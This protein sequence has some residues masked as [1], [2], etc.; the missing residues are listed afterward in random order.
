MNTRQ[1]FLSVLASSLIVACGGHTA[2]SPSTQFFTLDDEPS[3]LLSGWNTQ[4]VIGVVDGKNG[5]VPSNNPD[6]G[7]F[8]LLR[9]SNGDATRIPLPKSSSARQVV[10]D[11][12]FD[13]AT[14]SYVFVY[15]N[16]APGTVHTSLAVNWNLAVW[17]PGWTSAKVLDKQEVGLQ[18]WVATTNGIVFYTKATEA[19]GRTIIS[20][21][22]SSE[23]G[24]SR[25]VEVEHDAARV[26]SDGPYLYFVKRKFAVGATEPPDDQLRSGMTESE[27]YVDQV[28]TR[29]GKRMTLPGYVRSVA[30]LQVTAGLVGLSRADGTFDVLDN[31]GKLLHHVAIEGAMR[32]R[33]ITPISQGFVFQVDQINSPL[34]FYSAMAVLDGAAIKVV[35]IVTMGDQNDSYVTHMS[36]DNLI[37][38]TD[39]ATEHQSTK[40]NDVIRSNFWH[41]ATVEWILQHSHGVEQLE[42]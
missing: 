6:S 30:S 1:L 27:L 33:Y 17:N 40:S 8:T 38:W 11:G 10:L 34:H 36:R 39:P 13:E 5:Y 19:S 2:A 32:V 28:D 15:E 14:G 37:Y 26:L 4:G 21:Y 25:P 16:S 22:S 29:T 9:N 35:R 31:H 18:P 42:S 23:D 20:V 3:S 41:I 24:S 7:G 12:T